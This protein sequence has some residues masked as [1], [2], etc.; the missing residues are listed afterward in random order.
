M[1][2]PIN[3]EILRNRIIAGEDAMSIT[4]DKYRPQKETVM[5]I[6]NPVRNRL[7]QVVKK[8]DEMEAGIIRK[9]KTRIMPAI[10][11]ASIIT[12]PKVK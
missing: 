8:S 10:F 5:P 9:A 12:N 4:Q 2:I 1:I 7:D 11:T 3:N 6:I